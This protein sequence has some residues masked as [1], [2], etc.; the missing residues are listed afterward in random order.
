[1]MTPEGRFLTAN[2][3]L[4]RM[5]GYKSPE[6]LMASLDDAPMQLY[7][8]V[9]QREELLKALQEEGVVSNMETEV[10]RADGRAMWIR[11]NVIAVKNGMGSVF[12]V[13]IKVNNEVRHVV[14]FFS[15]K[16]VLPDPELLQMLG[17]IGTQLGHLVERKSAEEALRKSEMRKA[18]ILHSALD[19]IIS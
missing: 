13:P 10:V 11:E 16:V 12:G 19:C 4:A 6:H 18:A 14:E 9:G 2:H 1:Q 5:Y 17:I 8:K 7:V 15:P 3:S